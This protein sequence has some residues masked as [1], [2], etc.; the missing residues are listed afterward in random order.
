MNT[1]PTPQ[2]PQTPAP[3]AGKQV[4]EEPAIVLERALVVRAQDAGPK[5]PWE[6][7][8]LGPLSASGGVCP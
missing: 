1:Q 3:V 2:T 5:L 6:S 7:G 4:W 8:L